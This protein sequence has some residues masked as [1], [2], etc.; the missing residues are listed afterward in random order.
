MSTHLEIGADV[1]NG[2]RSAADELPLVNFG[3]EGTV[4]DAGRTGGL[5]KRIRIEFLYRWK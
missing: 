2:L 5:K 1:A 3:L 4:A